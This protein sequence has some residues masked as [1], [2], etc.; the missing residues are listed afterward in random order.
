M[1]IVPTLLE[2][3][4]LTLLDVIMV[5]TLLDVMMMPTLLDV[6]MVPTLLDVMMVPNLLHTVQTQPAHTPRSRLLSPR[7][8]TATW[9]RMSGIWAVLQDAI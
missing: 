2:M 3:K 4:E 9:V 7:F 8:Q 1:V 5:P 6:M